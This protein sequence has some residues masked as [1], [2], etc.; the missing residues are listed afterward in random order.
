[1]PDV[2]FYLTVYGG[3]T[4]PDLEKLLK[5][6]GHVVD[7][8]ILHDVEPWQQQQY[9]LAVCAQAEYIG[10]V[11]GVDAY[12]DISNGGTSSLTIGSFSISGGGGGSTSGG[13]SSAGGASVPCS[14]AIAYLDKGCLLGRSMP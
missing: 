13:S 12:V 2:N 6:A 11:G 7:N 4:Y 14:A 3:V 8:Y 1:M 5:R 9:D 10:S